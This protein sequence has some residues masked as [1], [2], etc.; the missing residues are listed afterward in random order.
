M[1]ACLGKQ[2]KGGSLADAEQLAQ[3]LA[4][5]CKATRCGTLVVG[6]DDFAIAKDLVEVTGAARRAGFERVMIGGRV[7]CERASDEDD[8]P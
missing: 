5:R 4:T 7:R 8:E 6:I 2:V 1:Q 3:R